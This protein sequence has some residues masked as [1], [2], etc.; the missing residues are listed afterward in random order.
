MQDTTIAAEVAEREALKETITVPL[1]V[2]SL[3]VGTS[4]K[5]NPAVCMVVETCYKK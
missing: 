1:V 5:L 4:V 2:E 3:S